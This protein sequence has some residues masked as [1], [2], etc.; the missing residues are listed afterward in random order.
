MNMDYNMTISISLVG[1]FLAKI[2]FVIGI[3]FLLCIVIGFVREIFSDS[4][5]WGETGDRIHIGLSLSIASIF[6]FILFTDYIK[7][8]W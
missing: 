5:F 2:F 1:V 3:F 4:Q 6:A 7:F 8:V